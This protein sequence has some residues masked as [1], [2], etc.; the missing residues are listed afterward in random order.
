[1]FVEVRTAS[2]DIERA[3]YDTTQKALRQAT[4]SY[5]IFVLCQQAAAA[6]TMEK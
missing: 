3:P 4:E 1:M 6:G 5:M 2:S